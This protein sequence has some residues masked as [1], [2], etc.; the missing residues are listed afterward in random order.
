MK[1]RRCIFPL[2][3]NT[4]PADIVA[5]LNL[6]DEKPDQNTGGDY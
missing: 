5:L 2:F 1:N 3:D 6:G 4:K